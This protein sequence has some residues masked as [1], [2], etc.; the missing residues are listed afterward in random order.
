MKE[1]FKND[2]SRSIR[3]KIAEG[4]WLKQIMLRDF[5]K[6]LIEKDRELSQDSENKRLKESLD[7][8]ILSI[9]LLWFVK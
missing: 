7:E 3:H 1:I 9:E 5:E 6:T 8:I 2:V 4:I